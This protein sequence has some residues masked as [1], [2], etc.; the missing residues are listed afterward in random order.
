MINQNHLQELQEVAGD[1]SVMVEGGVDF[2]FIPRLVLPEGCIPRE[3]PALLCI[4][5]HGGYTTRLFLPAIIP[6]K[7]MPSQL[8]TTRSP[9]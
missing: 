9:W 4:G 1:V 7:G 3:T 6:G 8:D 5:Q 2:V